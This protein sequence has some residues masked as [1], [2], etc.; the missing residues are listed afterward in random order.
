MAPWNEIC[1]A[2]LNLFVSFLSVKC[3]TRS[4]GS[5]LTSGV[6]SP[7]I[8]P[9]IGA[10]FDSSAIWPGHK[11]TFRCFISMDIFLSEYD[12]FINWPKGIWNSQ[13][14]EDLT[15]SNIYEME[16]STHRE[17]G[18]VVLLA[19]YHDDGEY[20]CSATTKDSP[21]R[22]QKIVRTLTVLSETKSLIMTP[23][24]GSKISSLEGTTESIQVSCRAEL[25]NPAAEITWTLGG[26]SVQADPRFT[27]SVPEIK[28]STDDDDPRKS[29][30]SNIRVDAA[31]I[32]KDLNNQLLSCHAKSQADATARIATVLLDVQYRPRVSMK[33][34]PVLIHPQRTSSITVECVADANPA[35]TANQFRWTL[36]G[37][38]G[39]LVILESTVAAN[40]R[41]SDAAVLTKN[42]II[43]Q[44]DPSMENKEL[45]CEASNE[46]GGESFS[47]SAAV[48]LHF[49]QPPAFTWQPTDKVVK[50][51][52]SFELSCQVSG[53]PTP[54]VTWYRSTNAE[55]KIADG[56]TFRVSKAKKLH[57]GMYTCKA[58]STGFDPIYATAEIQIYGEPV[59][60]MDAKMQVEIG[61]TAQ[62]RCD[63]DASVVKPSFV[64]WKAKD[65]PISEGIFSKY[66]VERTEHDHFVSL[67]LT[68]VDVQEEDFGQ[69]NCTAYNE[70]GITSKILF[71]EETGADAKAMSQLL[72]IV[73]IAVGGLFF[74]SLLTLCITCLCYRARKNNKL[75]LN[76]CNDS[77]D[78]DKETTSNAPPYKVDVKPN[79]SQSCSPSHHLKMSHNSLDCSQTTPPCHSHSS[80]VNTM[81]PNAR[82]ASLDR[83]Y[84]QGTFQQQQP[85]MMGS[86]PMNLGHPHNFSQS[87]T[88]ALL[89]AAS[90]SQTPKLFV[91]SD[92]YDKNRL[93]EELY[94]FA[95]RENNLHSSQQ[96]LMGSN[97]PGISAASSSNAPVHNHT[98]LHH[99]A[100]QFGSAQGQAAGSKQ[101]LIQAVVN[102]RNSLPINSLHHHH[103][104][105]LS[106]QQICIDSD[107]QSVQYSS[108]G[109][110]SSINPPIPSHHVMPSDQI[111]SAAH[112][113]F[114]NNST[115]RHGNPM[116]LGVMF[117]RSSTMDCIGDG[118]YA[119]IGSGSNATGS[120]S[121]R[122]FT[123]EEILKHGLRPHIPLEIDS[124]L[125]SSIQESPPIAT[126]T[127]LQLANKQEQQA[128][129]GVN[130]N[131]AMVASG[132]ILGN[133]SMHKE[134]SPNVSVGSHN[135][136]APVRRPLKP[137]PPYDSNHSSPVNV[138]GSLSRVVKPSVSL[139]QISKSSN[140]LNS[141]NIPL[142]L[143][144]KPPSVSTFKPKGQI[145]S[146][147][148]SLNRVDEVFDPS[149]DSLPGV[150]KGG[151]FQSDTTPMHMPGSYDRSRIHQSPPA[152]FQ[153]EVDDG[154][155]TA[156]EVISNSLAVRKPNKTSVAQNRPVSYASGAMHRDR[157]S[158]DSSEL[159]E[160]AMRNPNER[161]AVSNIPMN[162]LNNRRKS[163]VKNKVRFCDE[164]T[165]YPTDADVEDSDFSDIS[166]SYSQQSSVPVNI[167]QHGKKYP[168]PT[169]QSRNQHS[170][171]S[172]PNN[173]FAL[174]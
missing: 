151:P 39:Q 128:Y 47:V 62:L 126:T 67:V 85:Q 108:L 89:A 159:S 123:S 28:G 155:E 140:S 116:Q 8:E 61:E 162:S 15:P 133:M 68:I 27:I 157:Q 3:S 55:D 103:A 74:V 156:E 56:T 120:C 80:S 77:S 12:F 87:N 167:T 113:M 23:A 102:H 11:T 79:F 48:D 168:M 58:L 174:V 32:T 38:A 124:G 160:S 145:G 60:L 17:I 34:D 161:T 158:S 149:T 115:G 109:H 72:M 49:A 54:N 1:Y 14:R 81:Q 7:P 30:T 105:N 37:G 4:S 147:N 51:G 142:A 24:N 171:T 141:G 166:S 132:Q 163:S 26:K 50:E 10:E 52:D 110:S 20:E 70:A 146:S 135:S 131:P 172:S 97:Q 107:S 63:V 152:R 130:L 31:A 92:D 71:L 106:N 29:T 64:S 42:S 129:G 41:Q 5:S 9:L 165:S 100:G 19:A 173:S 148:R 137:P 127:L 90:S 138:G 35:P 95:R 6:T 36:D 98:M 46:I 104:H 119:F 33:L 94:K 121:D 78:T 45:K 164:E 57:N 59:I 134:N 18:K 16:N 82:Q 143:R 111:D 154:E 2:V 136:M 117:P 170:L 125:G 21:P 13:I 99:P 122:S 112:L 40:S 96:L 66:Q 101:Q 76:A 144:E 75:T 88:A 22:S 69:Y 43:I 139:D 118:S 73:A 86:V 53:K 91:S 114:M 169:D 83:M 25:A 65:D 93:N 44:V 150:T 153:C 84:I